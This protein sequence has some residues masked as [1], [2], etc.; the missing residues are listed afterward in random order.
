MISFRYHVVTIVAVFL[1]LGVGVLIGTTVVKQSLIDQLQSKANHA[2][3]TARQLDSEITHLSGELNSQ[4]RFIRAIEPALVKDQ[5][6]GTQVVMVTMDGVDPSEVDGVRTALDD[7]GASVVAAIVATTR[8][9]LTDPSARTELAS[10]I[11]AP[12]TLSPRQ[13]SQRAGGAIGARLTGGAPASP[14][15]DLLQ[16]LA[17]D[18]FLAIRPAS[19]PDVAHIGGADQSIVLLSGNA[20]ATSSVD[21]SAFLTPLVATVLERDATRPV[22]AA[23]TTQAVS[24]FVA[25]V[26]GDPALDSH[27]VTVDNA[28]TVEGQ[29]AVVLGLR[30]LQLSPG[31]GGDYGVSCGSCAPVPSPGP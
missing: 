17:N 28:D 6:T 4:A 15:P 21:P 11:G 8:M 7:S 5:L 27:L 26:R 14:Q 3:T 30:A 13:L 2:V 12:A 10:V 29:V 23:E 19:V 16:Q 18:G 31:A 22:V 9:A 20:T 25:S 24:P 1:A